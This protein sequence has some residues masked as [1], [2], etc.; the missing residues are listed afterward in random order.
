MSPYRRFS[1]CSEGQ[2][3]R[4]RRAGSFI[5]VRGGE[6]HL[7]IPG[8]RANTYFVIKP[9]IQYL[10]VKLSYGSFETQSARLRCGKAKAAFGQL[11]AVLRTNSCLSK[12]E[13]LRIYRSCVWSVPEYG[14]SQVGLD[15][16]AIDLVCSTVA[17]HLRKILR[18]FE[19]GV[20]NKQVFLTAGIDPARL[21]LRRIESKLDWMP[22]NTGVILHPIRAR[23]QRIRDNLC[24]IIEA[25]DSTLTAHTAESSVSCPVCGLYFA[26]E[27][28]LNTHIKSCHPKVHDDSR[29]VFVKARHSING[30]PQCFFCLK[31]LSDNH[32]LEKHITTGGCLVVKTALSKG[33]SMDDL[34][35]EISLQHQSSP[36]E[37][38]DQ[39]RELNQAKIL[40]KDKHPMYFAQR[41]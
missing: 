20:P 19:R 27:L 10:G 34:E 37:V 3:L 22:E 30:L 14:L 35:Q 39:I 33:Q 24:A 13:R 23:L 38:P 17:M 18:I 31:M 36:P 29:V 25:G 41:H 32:S 16:R 26:N 5:C 2:K 21:L 12:V 9:E 15:R 1:Y 4:R 11:R 28:G 8:E 6:D 7:R 40:L